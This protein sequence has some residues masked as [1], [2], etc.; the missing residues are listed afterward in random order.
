MDVTKAVF[1]N[2]QKIQVN[3]SKYFLALNNRKKILK[4]F[5]IGF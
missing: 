1:I 4:C 3:Q 5:E 2:I